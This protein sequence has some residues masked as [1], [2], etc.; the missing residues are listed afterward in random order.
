[1][2]QGCARGC[3]V[4]P[5]I[6]L[7]LTLLMMPPLAA[8]EEAPFAVAVAGA[9]DAGHWPFALVAPLEEA[10]FA[11]AVAGAK[12]AGHWPFALMA[13]LE[14]APFACRRCRCQGRRAVAIFAGGAAVGCRRRGACRCRWCLAAAVRTDGVVGAFGRGADP[15]RRCRTQLGSALA[16]RPSIPGGPGHQARLHIAPAPRCVHGLH[17]CPAGYQD[18]QC[19]PR[20]QRRATAGREQLREPRVDEPR[21]RGSGPVRCVAA[22][23]SQCVRD[24][25]L[26]V[27]QDHHAGHR[28]DSPVDGEGRSQDIQAYQDDRTGRFCWRGRPHRGGWLAR[29]FHPRRFQLQPDRHRLRQPV[30]RPD[31][32]G[33]QWLERQ[34]PGHPPPS[35][36]G[37]DRTGEPRA[38]RRRLWR[39]RMW[40]RSRSRPFRGRSIH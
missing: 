3:R 23:L 7:L 28:D 12:D 21:E 35:V 11:V 5:W 32:H 8:A 37:E 13:P 22:A 29:L 38:L 40:A 39:C 34:G 26:R 9:K 15:L 31:R 18:K 27:Q 33:P 10:P 1:M 17:L 24:G 4:R 36:G 16:V 19:E 6:G 25:R 14:E 30:P 20:R 2:R